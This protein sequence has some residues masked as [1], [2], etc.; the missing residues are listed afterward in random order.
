MNI[1]GISPYLTAGEVFRSPSRTA[2]LCEAFWQYAF[3]T[4]EDIP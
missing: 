2:R 1:I 3:T 4:Y